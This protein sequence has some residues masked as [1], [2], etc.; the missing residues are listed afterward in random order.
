MLLW[1]LYMFGARDM[2]F[3]DT[4]FERTTNRGTEVHGFCKANKKS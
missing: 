4:N 3:Y 1:Y 2:I